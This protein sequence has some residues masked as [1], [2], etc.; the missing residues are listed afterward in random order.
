MMQDF[1]FQ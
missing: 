1:N